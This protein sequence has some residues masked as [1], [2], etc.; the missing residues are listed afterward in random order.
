MKDRPIILFPHSY[1]PETDV[2]NIL[3]Y[4]EAITV[5]QPWYMESPAST[6]TSDRRITMVRPPEEMK[7]PED[8]RKLLAEYRLWMMQN[9]G[10]TPVIPN[11]GEDTTWEIRHSLRRKDRGIEESVQE[12][13]LKWH[14]ILHLERELEADRIS[15][16]ELLL[17]VKTE[18]S[19]LAEA[20]GETSPSHSLL[21][22]LHLPKGPPSIEERH[23][24]QV[25]SAWFGLFR[26][27][28]PKNGILLT[29]APDVL[30]YTADL[31]EIGLPG[32][33]REEGV[34]SLHTIDLPRSSV[35]SPPEND[36]VRAGLSGKT[37]ILINSR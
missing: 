30:E 18:K 9:P 21:D 19:P 16:D 8:F 15:A 37:L 29:V 36:P 32:L 31:F 28:L 1:L 20:L 23:I 11:H 17:R 25:L 35:E 24:R 4:F 5:C 2:D 34:L 7:P 22:D 13:A 14:L 6:K 33:L 10:Y 26:K 3:S 27:A 12:E